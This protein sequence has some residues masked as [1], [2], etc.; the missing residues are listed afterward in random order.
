[1]KPYQVH[2]FSDESKIPDFLP[3]A[4]FFIYENKRYL[5]FLVFDC[6][7]LKNSEHLK[8]VATSEI[9]ASGIAP[10]NGSVP[11]MVELQK[12]MAEIKK[13]D[14]MLLF[15]DEISALFA[16]FSIFGQKATFFVDYE[17]S[18]AINNVLQ[19]RNVEY[20]DH[21]D[22][23]KLDKL[24]SA[25]SE[26]VIVID[27]VYEWTGSVGPVN[28]LIKTAQ[29]NECV[30]IGNELNSFGFLGR[31]GRGFID[32]FNCYD[33]INIEIGSFNKFLGGFGTYIGA[34]RYLVN[35]IKENTSALITAFPQFMLS[36]NL[37]GLE[38]IKSGKNHKNTFQKLWKNS[39]Y[40]ITRL[41]QI[42]FSTISDTP[43]IVVSFNNNEEAGEFTK[44]LFFEQIIVAQNKE[45]I[46]LCLSVEHSK[47]DIDY[48]LEKFESVGKELGILSSD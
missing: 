24:L 40:F 26:K 48:C 25:K 23:E 42:G 19:Y 14:S 31:E 22:L 44:K 1:M 12:A 41:K 43:I 5:N 20:Y 47:D 18:P 27:G 35:K 38:L 6:F 30:I 10:A 4:P 46:R 11:V 17:T 21:N 9:E 2:L 15:P 3:S 34:K 16:V 33:A 39:R 45:R 37:T 8:E 7:H 13:I 28:A 29:E 36:V 32:L